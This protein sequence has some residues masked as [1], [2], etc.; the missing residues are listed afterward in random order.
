MYSLEILWIS[1]MSDG[2]TPKLF[3]IVFASEGSVP[4]EACFEITESDN[5]LVVCPEW[6]QALVYGYNYRGKLLD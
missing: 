2:P 3:T 6:S 1:A 5:G 4:K